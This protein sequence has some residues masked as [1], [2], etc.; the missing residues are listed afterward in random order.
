MK[1]K[2]GIKIQLTAGFFGGWVGIGTGTVKCIPL[3]YIHPLTDA[4]NY[5]N[6]IN[7]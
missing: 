2:I 7:Q 4:I 3:G 1:L 6:K 5:D